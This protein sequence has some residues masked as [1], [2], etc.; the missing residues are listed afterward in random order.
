MN[1][2]EFGGPEFKYRPRETSCPDQSFLIF[3]QSF[4]VNAEISKL[5]RLNDSEK[6]T[7]IS[8]QMSANSFFI[9]IFSVLRKES[10]NKQYVYMGKSHTW[11]TS[12]FTTSPE[13]PCIL[14]KPR[15]DRVNKRM[16]LV[17]ILRKIKKISHNIL[18]YFFKLNFSI[19]LPPT[20]LS[21]KRSVAIR[22]PNYTIFSFSIK[23]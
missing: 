6:V 16:P 19:I 20:H 10:L 7:T 15:S 5:C 14:W 18:P 8:L 22:F 4:H 1:C 23:N 2:S 9:H 13:F 17:P 12:S 11:D 3:L 21:S